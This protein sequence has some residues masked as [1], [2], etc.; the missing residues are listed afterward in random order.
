[1][2]QFLALPAD[3]EVL[4]RRDQ[5]KHY[6]PLTRQTLARWQWEKRGPRCYRIGRVCVYKVGEIRAWLKNEVGIQ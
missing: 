6:L 3:D 5:I 1:M 4:I 2:Q